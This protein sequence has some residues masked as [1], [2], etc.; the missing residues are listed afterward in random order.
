MRLL[1]AKILAVLTG[2]MIIALAVIFAMA[3]NS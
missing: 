3:Q 1:L 2:V